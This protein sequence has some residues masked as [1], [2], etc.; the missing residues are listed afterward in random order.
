MNTKCGNE[1]LVRITGLVRRM[2]SV[3]YSLMIYTV[4]M[5]LKNLAKKG[6]IFIADISDDTEDGA[7][8]QSINVLTYDMPQAYG[9]IL[10]KGSVEE[11]D[12]VA[13]FHE[14]TR[15]SPSL[16]VERPDGKIIASIP[17]ES[18]NSGQ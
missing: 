4:P 17:Y 6:Q 18:K 2:L 1:F 16:V 15:N 5:I 12:A 14:K 7:K 8:A 11:Q 10:F 13:A 9:G 3:K